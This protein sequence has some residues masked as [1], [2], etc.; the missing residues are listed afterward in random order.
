MGKTLKTEGILYSGKEEMSVAEII[1]Q[2]ESI[3]CTNRI[4]AEFEHLNVNKIK[5]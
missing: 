1:E 3:Y 2:L 5:F 4:T